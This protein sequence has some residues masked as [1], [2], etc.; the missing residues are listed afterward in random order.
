MNLVANGACDV[1]LVHS[2]DVH[3]GDRSDSISR[4]EIDADPLFFLDSQEAPQPPLSAQ[5]RRG[6]RGLRLS[7]LRIGQ[8][9]TRAGRWPRNGVAF[10]KASA[11]SNRVGSWNGLATSWIATGNPPAP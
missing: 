7:L 2:S 3:E 9:A 5:A 10:S 6:G 1:V 4:D 8:A 11:M